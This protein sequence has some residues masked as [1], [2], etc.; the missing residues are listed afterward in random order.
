[1][2]AVA[3]AGRGLSSPA[4]RSRAELAGDLCR[5]TG[6]QNIVYG[7]GALPRTRQPTLAAR[8]GAAIAWISRPARGSVAQGGRAPPARPRPVSWTIS[9]TRRLLHVAV[10]RCPYPH[11]RDRA[12]DARL[13][14]G[15]QGVE[16]VMLG[17]AVVARTEPITCSGRSPG[18]ASTPYFAMA[19][20]SRST[21]ASRSSPSPP[22][23]VRRRGRPRPDRVDYEPLPTWSMP[24]RRWSLA[25]RAARRC[26]RQPAR[27]NPRG[28]GRARRRPRP[29]RRAWSRTASASTASRPSPME[30]PRR[31]SRAADAEPARWKSGPRRR[32]RTSSGASSPQALRMPEI[33]RPRR[34][35]R[36]GGGFGLKLGI[37]P[38]DVSLASWRSTSG[39]P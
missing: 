18:A 31:R 20:R 14:L 23:T 4:R 8:A 19:G 27:A 5:C 15:M 16:A 3:L 26:P 2:T 7:R 33:R 25:R 13:A 30:T 34:R 37:Y 22:R 1:M 39:A 35:A 36:L 38:E 6:Y 10:A 12:I 29:G 11:A 17:D 21:R 28:E 24:R 9:T 32:R